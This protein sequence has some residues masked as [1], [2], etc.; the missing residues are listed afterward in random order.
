MTTLEINGDIIAEGVI[1]HVRIELP[2][3]ERITSV[4][5]GCGGFVERPRDI[6]IDI[7][8]IREEPQIIKSMAIR[9]FLINEM[10]IRDGEGIA[11]FG[12]VL[13]DSI[14][15]YHNP[16]TTRVSFIALR[17]EYNHGI[18]SLFK[19][20]YKIRRCKGCNDHFISYPIIQEQM[21]RVGFSADI[22]EKIW[23]DDETFD[24]L[25]CNCHA[26]SEGKN[27]ERVRV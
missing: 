26:K 25:C 13:V 14:H 9:G 4:T 2:N 10:V 1:P 5:G 22:I 8:F 24:F 16:P 7:D 18:D 27:L 20:N 15:H 17:G 3:Y 19:Y 23:N 21:H 11:T 12:M 6:E